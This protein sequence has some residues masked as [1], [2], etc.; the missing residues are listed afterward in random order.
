MH[1][2]YHFIYNSIIS[3]H[4]LM[5]YFILYTYILYSGCNYC[6]SNRLTSRTTILSFDIKTHQQRYCI[7]KGHNYPPPLSLAVIGGAPSSLVPPP[8]LGKDDSSRPPPPLGPFGPP[9]LVCLME[10]Y[11]VYNDNMSLNIDTSRLMVFYFIIFGLFLFY[12]KLT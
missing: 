2:L 1:D 11:C 12:C 5:I 8:L 9:G 3:I 7:L 10:Y 4:L 6:S